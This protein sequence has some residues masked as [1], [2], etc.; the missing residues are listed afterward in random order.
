MLSRVNDAQLIPPLACNALVLGDS[1]WQLSLKWA[2]ARHLA[3]CR[4]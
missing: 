2:E 1:E 3:T 4:S